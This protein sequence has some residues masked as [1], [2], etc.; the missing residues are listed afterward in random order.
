MQEQP[1]E[2][3]LRGMVP[4]Q[5]LE[6][7]DHAWLTLYSI[8]LGSRKEFKHTKRVDLAESFV[9]SFWGSMN[10]LDASTLALRF[11]PDGD[12]I[13]EGKI[14]QRQS[15]EGA[16]IAVVQPCSSNK[17]KN[18]YN[19]KVTASMLAALLIS[20]TT[21]N[22]AYSRLFD[23]CLS[24]TKDEA[25]AASDV[26]LSPHGFE[27]PR[28]SDLDVFRG[29]ADLLAAKPAADRRRIELSLHWYDKSLRSLGVDSF[30]NNWIAIET[31]A[32]PD[33]S[34]IKP[35][36]V[37][38]SGIYSLPVATVAERFCVGRLLDLRSKIVHD[39]EDLTVMAPLSDYMNRLYEDLL[40]CALGINTS[41]LGDIALAPSFSFGA[42]L[43]AP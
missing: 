14:S 27:K 32:M 20:T 34:N 28:V 18:E 5:W 4:R 19:L 37:Q 30:L 39:G 31:L 25:T 21:R 33:T 12:F 40:H 35:I 17:P 16:W 43:H 38:L 9:F 26:A 13:V 10:Y 42:M 8:A 1:T 41:R 15:G 7:Y 22:Y 29:A 3:N 24:L 2:H 11:S 6:S 23:N 36:N